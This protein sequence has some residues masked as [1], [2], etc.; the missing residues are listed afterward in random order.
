MFVNIVYIKVNLQ[1]L[2]AT[3][4]FALRHS[5]LHGHDMDP[6]RQ[7]RS[8]YTLLEVVDELCKSSDEEREESS[9][10]EPDMLFPEAEFSDTSLDR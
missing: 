4:L 1:G 3:I 2:G 8:F 5:T 6:K 9:D 10:D 7:K